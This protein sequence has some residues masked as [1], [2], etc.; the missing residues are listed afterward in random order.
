MSLKISIKEALKIL[1]LNYNIKGV[2]QELDGEVDFNF[3]IESKCGKNYL[4][5]ISGPNFKSDYIDFQINLLDYL[6]KNCK[7]ETA[8]NELT[9]KGNKFCN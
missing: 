7:I 1:E 8:S 4:L 3:K 9:I 2:I 5:K 6:N